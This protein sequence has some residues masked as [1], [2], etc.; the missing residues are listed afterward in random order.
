MRRSWKSIFVQKE[1][2]HNQTS[3]TVTKVNK[4]KY[5]FD[6]ANNV[7]SCFASSTGIVYNYCCTHFALQFMRCALT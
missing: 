5:S 3:E 6:S 2:L 1:L 7:G 4:L